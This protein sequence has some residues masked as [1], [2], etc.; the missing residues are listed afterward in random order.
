MIKSHLKFAKICIVTQVLNTKRSH[1]SMFSGCDKIQNIQIKIQNG[2]N[3]LTIC[4]NIQVL[5][6]TVTNTKRSLKAMFSG[7]LLST[8]SLPGAPTVANYSPR[9]ASQIQFFIE[10]RKSISANL[11]LPQACP[12]HS[13]WLC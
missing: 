13:I 4:I 3:S 8:N 1:K 6:N 11:T 10:R 2:Q 9:E 7:C 12:R 5:K